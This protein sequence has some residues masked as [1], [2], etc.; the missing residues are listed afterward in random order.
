MRKAL[1]ETQRLER[2][3]A[4]LRLKLEAHE[5]EEAADRM[6]FQQRGRTQAPGDGGAGAH[7]GDAG[8]H[9]PVRAQNGGGAQ[10]RPEEQ[11]YDELSTM[12]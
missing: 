4:H 10:A 5:H 3:V 8:Q 7:R 1:D 2:I 9:Q 6:G 12:S 11:R